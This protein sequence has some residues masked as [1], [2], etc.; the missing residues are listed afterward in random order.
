MT[1]S[2]EFE[3]HTKKH[4]DFIGEAME[5]LGFPP[6][7]SPYDLS[8]D[9][10]TRVWLKA[11]DLFEEYSDAEDERVQADF[12]VNPWRYTY[13]SLRAGGRMWREAP[14]G[15]RRYADDDEREAKARRAE[16]ER[17]AAAKRQAEREAANAAWKATWPP[18]IKAD[19]IA[20]VNKYAAETFRAPPHVERW[21]RVLTALGEEGDEP[22][23]TVEEAQGYLDRGWKRWRPVVEY[24]R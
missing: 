8:D 15:T 12:R 4:T 11:S 22:A 23:M 10:M 7:T 2:F 19:L 5:A 14:D 9:D 20:S 21:R 1:Y 16:E 17:A 24:L 6:H 18:E 3:S 13:Q